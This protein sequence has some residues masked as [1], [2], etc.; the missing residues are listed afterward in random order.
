MKA[1]IQ[2]VSKASVT[3][4]NEKVANIKN[5]LLILLGIVNEDT[6]EDINWL[7]KKITNLRIF[8]DENG[9]M[10]TSLLQSD[11]EVII[12]SQFTLQASTK[13]GNRPSYIK[14][15]KPDISIP[16]YEQF[17][18]QFEINLGKKV[19]TGEFGADMKVELINDG[20]VTII[21]DTKDKV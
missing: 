14:A 19:Q 17:V 18:S 8:N 13:K 15:A 7:S 16:L 3:I 9:I 6:Q 2:R 20:P 21:I 10:N 5:G 1:V 4:N 12:V 11:G